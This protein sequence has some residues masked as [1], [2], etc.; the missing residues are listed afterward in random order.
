MNAKWMFGLV[1]AAF[2][3]A[4]GCDDSATR[5]DLKEQEEKI[6]DLEKE[7]E[8]A[9][10]GDG[11]EERINELESTLAEERDKHAALQER[12]A[13]EDEVEQNL[14]ELDKK[15]DR[16]QDQAADA[17]GDREVMLRKE[18]AGLRTKQEQTERRLAELKAASGDS[19]ANVKVELEDAWNDVSKSVDQTLEKAKSSADET[20]EDVKSSTGETLEDLKQ[21]TDEA[22]EDAESATEE[23]LEE[24]E[25]S[26]EEV[27]KEAEAT[28]EETL[29][30]AKSSTEELFEDTKS[31]VDEATSDDE[32]KQ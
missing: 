25:G 2:L 15:I 4:A 13:Y 24:A 8:E 9:R 30:D 28:T 26:S 1:L 3:V 29:Q 6:A 19:W 11:S 22:V 7:L 32:A 27:L 5:K 12:L 17:T 23:S 31:T 20:V 10:K 18:I 14:R 16:L 21:S